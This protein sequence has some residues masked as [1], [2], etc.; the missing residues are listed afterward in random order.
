[1]HESFHLPGYDILEKIG[2]GGTSSVWKARQL[3]LDRLVAI[4]VLDSALQLDP[5]ALTRFRQEAQAA[6][7]LKHASIVQVYDTG[8]MDGRPFL[9]MEYVDGYTVG[10]LLQRSGPLTESNALLVTEAVAHALAYAWDKDCI[11]HLDIKPDNVLVESDGGIKVTDLGLAR[12]IGMQ[13]RRAEDDIIIGTPNYV[14]PEQ[15]EGMDQKTSTSSQK[16]PLE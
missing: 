11:I 2:E 16:V 8:E 5:A 13:R 14:S 15:A 7:R 3:S 9:V 10:D 4:K 1:M 6:A 12:F